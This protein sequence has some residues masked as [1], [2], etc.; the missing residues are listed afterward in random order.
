MKTSALHIWR[1]LGSE[2][3]AYFNTDLNNCQAF[4]SILQSYTVRFC[5]DWL[6][7]CAF[8]KTMRALSTFFR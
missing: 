1:F 2:V 6:D 4:V 5:W 8:K 7:L 3:L